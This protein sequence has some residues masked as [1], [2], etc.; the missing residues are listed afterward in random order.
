MT[1]FKPATE[2]GPRIG[3]ARVAL[4]LVLLMVA[5]ACSGSD[6]AETTATSPATDTTAPD[7]GDGAGSAGE[8]VMAKLLD[9]TTFDPWVVLASNSVMHHQLFN[10]LIFAVSPS[11]FE[12]E[13]LEDWEFAEDNS[14]VTL[15]LRSGVTFHDGEPFNAESIVANVARAQDESIGHALYGQAQIIETAEATGDLEAVLHFV[16]PVPQGVALDFLASFF[17][18]APSALDDVETNPVGT[19]PFEFVEWQPGEVTTFKRFENYFKPGLPKLDSIQIVNYADPSTMELAYQA[20]EIDLVQ[21]A[22]PSSAASY[23]ALEGT[24]IVQSNAPNAF[25]CFVLNVTEEPFDDV[26]VRQALAHA[27]NREAMVKNVLFGIGEPTSTIFFNPSHAMFDPDRLDPYPFDLDKAAD[28]LAEAGISEL[29]FTIDTQTAAAQSGGFA[30]ILQAD[31]RTIGID[32]EIQEMEGSVFLDRWR[33]GDFQ[34]SS[35]SSALLP[36]DPSAS[37]SIVATLRSDDGNNANWTDSEYRD[38]IAEAATTMDPDAR[39]ELYNQVRDII[40]DES[41]V[42][43]IATNPWVYVVRDGIEDLRWSGVFEFNIFE[44]TVGGR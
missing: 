41:F 40:T 34:A 39:S 7:S 35:A 19:G 12:G 10:P 29:T 44:N 31:L 28:L 13:L 14:S 8:L 32:A 20:G 21:R 33:G 22:D 30:Q 16:N 27:T 3:L 1:R 2:R 9:F 18:I 6:V 25:Y 5:A 24:T 26:R 42:I 36:R 38:L 11:E 17:I 23:E 4:A 43:P 15:H 37:F